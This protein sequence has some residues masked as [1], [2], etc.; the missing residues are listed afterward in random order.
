MEVTARL[1][2]N[3][4]SMKIKAKRLVPIIEAMREQIETRGHG[5]GGTRGKR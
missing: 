1:V 4:A 3:R 2:V 5:D